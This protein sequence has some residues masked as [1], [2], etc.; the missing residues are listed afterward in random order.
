MDLPEYYN[1]FAVLG[2]GAYGCVVAASTEAVDRETVA[3]K[4]FFESFTH[5]IHARRTLRELRFLRCLQHE[6]IVAIK[7]V[8]CSGP[9]RDRLDEIYVATE[10]R[11]LE[12]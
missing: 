12:G 9:T 7:T 3:I 4:K 8:F 6:N 10:A 5:S 2:Q 11:L 1:V